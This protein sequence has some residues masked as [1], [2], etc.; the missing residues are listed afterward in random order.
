MNN[1]CNKYQY[2]FIFSDEEYLKEHIKNC[3]DCAKKHEISEKTANLVKEIKP[4]IINENINKK[5]LVLLKSCSAVVLLCICLSWMVK[6]HYQSI[7]SYQSIL[8]MVK[9]SSIINEMGLPVD[10]YGLL[11]V[12]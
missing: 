1:N 5:R 3:P 2:L 9:E 7:S 12:H 8:L 6:S 4:Y 11:Q 10:E